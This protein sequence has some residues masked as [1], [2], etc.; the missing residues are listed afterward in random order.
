MQQIPWQCQWQGFCTGEG[1]CLNSVLPHPTGYCLGKH[2][3]GCNHLWSSFDQSNREMHFSEDNVPS[4]LQSGNYFV[5]GR[6]FLP[7][8]DFYPLSPV[9]VLSC[10]NLM[11]HHVCITSLGPW[12]ALQDKWAECVTRRR[13]KEWNLGPSL[14]T[15]LWNTL[16]PLITISKALSSLLPIHLECLIE[17]WGVSGMEGYSEAWT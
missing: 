11:L 6:L 1:S 12:D 15:A 3:Q 13:S 14:A 9:A 17:V 16:L 5:L 8:L 4:A 2:L 7:A 10:K